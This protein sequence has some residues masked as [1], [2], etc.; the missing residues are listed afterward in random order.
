[1]VSTG[2]RTG[3][4]TRVRTEVWDRLRAGAWIRVRTAL[5][6]GAWTR[7]WTPVRAGARTGVGARVPT[8]VWA[9]RLVGVAAA[10]LGFLLVT[11]PAHAAQ[12]ITVE[13][14]RQAG[15]AVTGR[16]TSY[17]I[18]VE[19]SGEEPVDV[20]VRVTVPRRMQD[21]TATGG[22]RTPDGV[23]WTLTVPPGESTAVTLAGVYGSA[24]P[25]DRV[26]P[27]RVALT[28]C[29]LVDRE[30]LAACDTDIAELTSPGWLAQWWWLA[31][32]LTVMVAAWQVRRRRRP[33]DE[34]GQW[35]DL[36]VDL[37]ELERPGEPAASAR[38]TW[39]PRP[40]ARSRP[41]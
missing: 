10:A 20:T 18:T 5:R 28:A 12:D 11:A 15:K 36:H 16:L 33:A 9:G 26:V 22:N 4:G 6:L 32:P 14:E 2:V 13:V 30:R 34:P 40:A 17:E 7:F 31:I 29:V 38:R 24:P 1:M 23:E 8:A 3:N 27:H 37:G 19:N 21:V 39:L 25:S 35:D 41:R